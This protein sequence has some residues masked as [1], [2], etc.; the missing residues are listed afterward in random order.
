M[1]S[2]SR[3]RIAAG[4]A[5]VSAS[6]IAV[7]PAAPSLLDLQRRPVRLTT[8][9]AG[10]INFP[11]V[12][13]NDLVANTTANW[14]GLTEMFDHTTAL[15]SLP[16]AVFS[17]G[18]SK[19]FSDLTSE[20]QALATYSAAVAA[21]QGALDPG[22]LPPLPNLFADPV[23]NPVSALS[24]VLQNALS[25]GFGS[26][27]AQVGLEGVYQNMLPSIHDITAQFTNIST[28][29]QNLLTGGSFSASAIQTDVTNIGTDLTSG[30]K[31]PLAGTDHDSERLPQRIPRGV[32]GTGPTQRRCLLGR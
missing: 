29:F 13:W 4:V 3:S 26:N 31:I 17:E 23:L 5:L 1:L 16:S 19:V 8:V 27:A 9:E 20:L 30:R 6:I 11:E 14:N 22:P 7:T 15:T 32:G 21:Q 28:Q 25:S 24:L 2:T 12:G 18:L 10:D